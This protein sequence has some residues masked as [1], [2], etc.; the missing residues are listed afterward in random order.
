MYRRYSDFSWLQRKLEQEERYKGCIL[1]PL[2]SKSV[3]GK[4]SQDLV[5]K[6]KQELQLYLQILSQHAMIKYDPTFKFFLACESSEEFDK[7]K[8]DPQPFMGESSIAV[9][10]L[11]KLQF[12]DTFNYLYSSIKSR[13]FDKEEPQ[14]IQTGL[15][16][17]EIGEKIAKYLPVIAKQIALLEA[18][19]AFQKDFA[20]GQEDLANMLE[21]LPEED[22][23]LE[24]ALND[25]SEY[26]L[27]Y[28]FLVRVRAEMK[29]SE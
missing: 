26:Y 28:S 8:A 14:E 6:R 4:N 27:K 24:K 22:A 7:L 16:L 3:M 10:S 2:P 9:A 5:E 18:R 15:K 12:H 21:D 11:K 25:S 23:E 19:L 1:P 20:S 17:I 29:H 13:Y